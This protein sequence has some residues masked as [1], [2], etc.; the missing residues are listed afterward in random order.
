MNYLYLLVDLGAL[1]V[2][3][4]FSFHP[5]IQLYKQY[6]SLWSAIILTTIPFIIWDS[7]FTHI[8]VWGFNPDYL[9]GIYF[10]GLPIEEILFFICIPYA[11]LFT[12]YCFR[13][14][15]SNTFSLKYEKLI[16]LIFLTLTLAGGFLFYDRLYT[17]YTSVFLGIT[18]VLSLI[19]R[20][21]WLSKFYYVHMFLLLPF[22]IVN[23]ILTGTGLEKPIVWYNDN[24]NMALRIVTIPM[25]DIFYGMLMLLINTCLFEY[26]MAFR[27][28]TL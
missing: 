18:L 10:W 14:Y 15:L 21:K 26:F 28:K 4:L 16:T 9:L 8:K 19:F 12:Y 2:P 22:F 6:P 20:L 11:C 7:H 3:L 24:E 27:R 23:G 25:E 5:K 1:S 17:F 13:L